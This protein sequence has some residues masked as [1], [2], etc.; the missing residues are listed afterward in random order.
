M[1]TPSFQRARHPGQREDRKQAILRVATEL[2]ERESFAKL[3]M[4]KVASAAD[5]AKGTLYL[6]FQTKEEIVLAAAE[7]TTKQWLAD[8]TSALEPLSSGN[9]LDE[10]ADA[11]WASLL[12]QEALVQ[13]LP[14]ACAIF[15]QHENEEW[16]MSYRARSLERLIQ[17]GQMLE[18]RVPDLKPE[19]GARFLTYAVALMTG[20]RQLRRRRAGKHSGRPRKNIFDIP[21]E[22][23]MRIALQVMLNGLTA[24]RT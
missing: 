24:A 13:I 21:I 7:E 22:E 9:S 11:A 10:I 8:L 23:E 18:T 16:A 20:L 12:R 1:A 3:T 5:L 4:A 15:E 17:A 6:Y 19:A 14:V 2:L